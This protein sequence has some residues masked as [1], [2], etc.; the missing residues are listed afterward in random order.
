MGSL[1]SLW[2]EEAGP[3]K[4]SAV[5]MKASTLTISVLDSEDVAYHMVSADD[6][7]GGKGVPGTGKLAVGVGGIGKLA[8]GVGAAV[9]VIAI[10]L[11]AT[12]LVRR[13]R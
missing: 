7:D 6:E 5:K 2:S 9:G 11:A 13:R 4:P 10:G 3:V 1:S 8:V 12:S